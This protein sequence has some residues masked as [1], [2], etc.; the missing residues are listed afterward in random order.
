[1][2][3]HVAQVGL[4]LNENPVLALNSCFSCLLCD[5]ITGMGL[6]TWLPCPY[7]EN[8]KFSYKIQW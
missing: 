4:K 5:E 6:Q 1:M 8:W 7:G 3:A 2:G